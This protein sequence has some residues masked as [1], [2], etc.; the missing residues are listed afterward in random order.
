MPILSRLIIKLSAETGQMDRE[1]SKATRKVANLGRDMQAA[2]MAMTAGLTLPL[3]GVGAAAIKSFADFDQAMKSSQAIMGNLSDTMKSDMVNAARESAKNTIFSAEESARSF[4]FLASAGLDAAA[5]IKTLPVVSRFAQAGM[6]DMALATDLLTDAQ[7]ALG[8]AI[9]RDAVANMQNMI[10]VSDVLVK[11]NTL[12]NASVQQFSE[13]LTQ[14][15]GAALRILGKDIEE[16]VAVLAAFADQGRKGAE[17]G[18]MLSIVLRDLQTKAIKNSEAFR[19]AGVT[20]FDASGEMRNMA[21]ILAD[22]EKKLEGASDQTK[23]ATLLQLGFA[24]KSVAALQAII[25]LSDQIREYEK[26]LRQAGGTT[27]EVADKQL[28]S[29]SAQ[30]KLLQSRVEDSAI[31][32][33]KDLAVEV[34]KLADFLSGS[35]L[36]AVEGTVGWFTK[37]PDPIKTTSF[38]L[39]ALTAAAG[40]AIYVLGG[41]MIALKA[42]LPILVAVK[43]A[44][45]AF[46]GVLISA[47]GLIVLLGVG[48][49]AAVWKAHDSFVNLRSVI[50][51]TRAAVDKEAAAADAAQEAAAAAAWTARDLAIAREKA[52]ATTNNLTEAT[53]LMTL[54]ELLATEAHS[55]EQAAISTL[56]STIQDYRDGLVEA[57]AP[58][59][60]VMQTADGIN[61]AFERMNSAL[62]ISQAELEKFGRVAEQTQDVY[63]V[64]TEEGRK[65]LRTMEDIR[66]QGRRT[67]KHIQTA[68]ERM[69]R[70]V[71]TIMTDMSRQMADLIFKGGK[72]AD[73]WK[74]IGK[75]ILRAAIEAQ[76][77]RIGKAMGDLISKSDVLKKAWE[78]IF[79]GGGGGVG[80]RGILAS[81]DLALAGT[82]AQEGAGGPGGPGGPGG[83]GAKGAASWANLA[84]NIGQLIQAHGRGKNLWRIELN[85][86]S[87]FAILAYNVV[88]GLNAIFI[89][90]TEIKDAVWQLREDLVHFIGPKLDLLAGSHPAVLPALAGAANGPAST[91][92]IHNYIDG[93]ELTNQLFSRAVS[94]IRV[95][96]GARN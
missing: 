89:A 36:P 47:P 91:V 9:R 65:V 23:K 17:A 59:I 57:Y 27:Q 46:A 51:E 33:G 11:A 18:T 28:E 78:A 56:V 70:Q 55:R 49:V 87:T 85:T 34:R 74:S 38:G 4:F 41:L 10:R 40:P 58:M 92:H 8:M 6:F 83:G 37:L 62:R 13:A 67:Y 53:R 88:P 14:K 79:G 15:A 95:A 42:L 93:R 75:A 73:V 52:T 61:Y 26:Q 96:H 44:S 12:A 20:V 19:A 25:G 16:G 35:L 29:F 31:V 82:R 94:E 60:D 54:Q 66:R 1:L 68:A 71:S 50:D 32:I 3:V 69:S 43:A 5:S 21:D 72:F 30:M 2:G 81:E 22:L 84:V 7:S 86:R 45:L 48:L 64:G 63:W 39:L 80:D 76:F 90:S 24:D 77:G